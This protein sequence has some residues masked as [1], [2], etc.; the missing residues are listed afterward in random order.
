MFEQLPVYVVINDPACPNKEVLTTPAEEVTFPLDAKTREM[1]RLLEAKFDQEDNC[2]GLA[3]PQVGYNKRILV[4]EAEE[5]EELQK[6]RPDFTDTLPKTIW[7]NPSW[8]PLSEEKFIDWEACFSVKDLAARVA[9]F[10][11]IS[12]EAWTPEGKKITGKA[13]GLLARI[14]QHE[15]DH[16]NGTLFIDH[17]PEDEV[18]TLE[19]ARKIIRGE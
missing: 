8:T 7:I 11:E 5:D 1:M 17:V 13:H 4:L 18:M 14:I 3:A 16:L 10:T 19:E 2:A 15:T 6:R 9:R 12:Y